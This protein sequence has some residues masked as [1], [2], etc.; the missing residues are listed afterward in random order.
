MKSHTQ[1]AIIG[2]G[3]MGVSLLYH[4]TK[5]GW[6]DVVLIEKGEL[7]SGSTW[8]AAGQCPH[9]VGSYNLA[10]VH[11]HSTELYKQLEK[12][13]GQSTGWHGCGSLRLAYAQKDLDWFHYVKGILINVGCSAEII[14]TQEISKIHPF[15]KLDG[16]IGAL[17]TP[18]D[19]HTD[20]T[21]TTNAM[22]KGARSGGAEIY[23]H[24][25][26]T[27]INHLPTG[28]W[29]LMTEK[30]KIISEHVV[31]AAGS[32]CPEVGHMVGL[33]N[34]PSINMIHHYLVTDEHPEIKKLG[35]ELPVVRDPHS[36]CYLRQ[37]GKG[38]LIGIYEKD[39]RCWAL[40]GMDW[41]F[42][43][44]LLEPELDRLEEH[45]NR[46]MDRI[47]QFR[48]VGIKRIIC[49]PIT[50]TPDGNFLAGPAPGLKN[51]WMFCAASVGIAQ[52]GGAGKYMAQWMTYG[53][54]D[55]NMLEFDPR[56]YLSWAHKDYA[57]AKS[58]DEYKRMYVTP[59]PNESLEVGRPIKTTPIYKK[60]QD[61][62]AMYIDAFGW[63]RPKWF[64]KNGIQEEYSFKRSNAFSYVQKEC[65]AVHKGVGILDLST[66][67]KFE[68]SGENSET[69]LDRL[70]ANRIPKKDGSIVLTHML[71]EK[72]RIQSELTITR[73]PN[74]LFY[75]LSSTASEIRDFDWFNNHIKKDEKVNIRN[76]TQN[77]GV[78]VLAGPHSRSVLSQQTNA[79]LSNEHFPWLK[80]KEISINDIPVRALR[81]NYLGELGWEL[82]H[83]MNQ[84][85]DLYKGF[86]DSGK[87]FNMTNFGTYAVN[88]LRIEK[89]YKGWGSELT[90]EIS[91]VEADMNRFY[92]L[93]T[94]NTFVGS[95]AIREKLDEG[96]DIKIVYL[97]VDS[98]D[99]D[100]IGNEPV[101]SQNKIIGVTTSGG[102]G[103]RVNKSLSFAYVKAELAEKESE[104]EIEI[105]GNKR[106]AKVLKEMAYDPANARLMS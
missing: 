28:E 86:M 40:D 23:R 8:H 63:E 21:S 70:C 25:R 106:K 59:L 50:H 22:A 104:F 19:G 5:E 54:A 57:V 80:G 33:K 62:G 90:G 91:L 42:D 94:K 12:E 43:M 27:N 66:F 95:E 76:V 67:S 83:P 17:H 31:N 103:F 81:I 41:K 1:V 96:I 84:M 45:L 72:G 78:L 99:A 46:G 44:E 100:A 77:Y 2:G 98:D 85:E 71:N 74:N 55:I 26:V 68:I 61:Q 53:D 60:L 89:A 49:G 48:D 101:Y 24:N 87:Q 37:E 88:S 35:K 34:I 97:E 58:T 38:L 14:S 3:I 11:F 73:F 52:G 13:T 75:V 51:F 93:N 9:F 92:N 105:Q 39:A 79:D 15:I 6:S 64:A 32:F 20:P 102:Y 4:L 82:H 65:E 29:E 7:T 56:R 69:F 18:E 16:I 36:S 47:P 10:K 30:G